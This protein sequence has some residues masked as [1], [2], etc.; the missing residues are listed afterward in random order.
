MKVVTIKKEGSNPSTVLDN[1]GVA[2]SFLSRM[3]GL[4]G[5][6]SLREDQG[7]IIKPCKS[8]HTMWMRFDIDVV[9]LDKHKN[10]VDIICFLKPFRT[11]FCR[12]A[13]YTLELAAGM[14]EKKDLKIGDRLGWS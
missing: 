5:K 9:F 12:D 8:I 13:F 7:L 2:E 1:A 14:A 11:A 3:K 10:I 6:K 4:M